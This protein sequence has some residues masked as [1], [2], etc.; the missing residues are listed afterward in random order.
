MTSSSSSANQSGTALELAH[1]CDA[2]DRSAD[3]LTVLN[4][5]RA[6]R[7]G[8]GEYAPSLYTEGHATALHDLSD[9]YREYDRPVAERIL[10]RHAHPL[11]RRLSRV[12]EEGREGLAWCPHGLGT[13]YATSWATAD[14]AVTSLREAYELRVQLSAGDARHEEDLASTCA[15]LARA[16]LMTSSFHEAV[17]IAEHE[18]SL[19]GRLFVTN[20]ARY[21][22]PLCFALLRLA[23]GRAPTGNEVEARRTALQAG[24]ACLTLVDRPG[25]PPAERALLL[26][27][28]A[29][30][31]SRT[32]CSINTRHPRRRTRSPGTD[33]VCR[34]FRREPLIRPDGVVGRHE[35]HG[36]PAASGAFATTL[37]CRERLLHDG[38]V[39]Q[40]RL[41][42]RRPVQQ[43]R[44]HFLRHGVD[45]GGPG[46]G[47]EPSH[48]RHVT[49]RQ[50]WFVKPYGLGRPGRAGPPLSSCSAR[51]SKSSAYRSN[52][53][54]A[55]GG[56]PTGRVT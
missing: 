16:L 11:Y 27:R 2:L 5:A 33:Q 18:V 44:L 12:T 7:H 6:V 24:Q 19:R 36:L 8:L 31:L 30:A 45:V 42:Y 10:L 35:A 52:R 37:V 3:A 9:L 32:G 1:S 38:T 26:C 41:P 14:R 53:S 55:V 56:S 21:E 47:R 17:R 34:V 28:L 13:S 48:E 15:Q 43:I 25:E 40:L 46:L 29:R 51:S 4:Q 50:R 49:V 54:S 20:R 39:P 22:R 23:E